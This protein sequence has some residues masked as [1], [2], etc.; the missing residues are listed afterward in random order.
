M[1]EPWWTC[2]CGS[3]IYRVGSG[4]RK[5]QKKV[6]LWQVHIPVCEFKKKKDLGLTEG[7]FGMSIVQWDQREL[8][9]WKRKN[10]R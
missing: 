5:S 6:D 10:S 8:K 4:K 2:S 3:P 1:T 7:S 9:E